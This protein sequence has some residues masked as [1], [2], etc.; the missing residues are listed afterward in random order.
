MRA[1]GRLLVALSLVFGLG[2]PLLWRAPLGP[3]AMIAVKGAGVGLLALAAALRARDSDGWLLTSVMAL[4]ALG[5]VLLEIDFAAGAAAFAAGHLAAIAL[6]L[7]NPR[8]GRVKRDLGIAVMLPALAVIIPL[9]M[10]DGR[11]EAWPFVLYALLLGTMAGSALLSRFP[12]RLVFAGALLFLISD[13]LIAVRLG[14]GRAD[15][16]LPIWLL[17]YL[18]Q[19]MIFL[20]VISSW[21]PRGRSPGGGGPAKLVEG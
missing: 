12:R 20:G 5:D 17:Y 7:R 4:G 6:Y 10:L 8:P 14:T 19:L 16:G 18:G 21:P 13:M 15:L 11:P 3:E 1:T 9:A 2:Y